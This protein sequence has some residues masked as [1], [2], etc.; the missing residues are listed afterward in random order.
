M[1][2]MF[3]CI[4]MVW[5]IY[6]ELSIG[7]HSNLNVHDKEKVLYLT[8]K[9]LQGWIRTSN[10]RRFISAVT[11]RATHLH[12]ES[13][14]VKAHDFFTRLKS[15]KDEK[16]NATNTHISCSNINCGRRQTFNT[17]MYLLSGRVEVVKQLKVWTK[18]LAVHSQPLHLGYRPV[19]FLWVPI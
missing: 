3:F 13:Q 10:S 2:Q 16:W 11:A 18:L 15:L 7:N 6:G 9:G 12:G 14:E 4:F 17:N 19:S 5:T 8:N 1:F